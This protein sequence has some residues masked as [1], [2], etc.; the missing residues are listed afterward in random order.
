MT[1]ETRK[2]TCPACPHPSPGR[3]THTM[4]ERVGDKVRPT[5]RLCPVTARGEVVAVTVQWPLS[6]DVIERVYGALSGHGVGGTEAFR[7]SLARNVLAAALDE[8][9][10]PAEGQRGSDA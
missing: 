10:T 8:H 7:R 1:T 3:H 5:S 9:G 4:W 2:W 6:D